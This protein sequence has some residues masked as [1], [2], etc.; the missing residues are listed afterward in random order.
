MSHAALEHMTSIYK[1]TKAEIAAAYNQTLPDIIAFNLKVVFCG[2]NPSLYSAAVSHHFARP[3]N[4][5]WKT[6]HAAQFTDRLLSPFEDRSLPKHGYGL[7]NIVPRA[8]ARADELDS[9]ELVLGQ[10]QL[11]AKMEKYQPMFLAVL[12][13]SAYRVAFNQPKARMGL[14][15]ETISG[16][17]IWVLPNPSGLNAHYQLDGLKR[18]YEE[19]WFAAMQA[20]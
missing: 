16:T 15:K 11:A 3:G 18:V 19:L 8:T 13:I 6:L 14:Q 5:F 1:P 7:T 10:Q 17:A 2:I 20:S 9:E 12:G 4:R